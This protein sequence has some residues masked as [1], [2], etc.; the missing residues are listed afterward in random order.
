VG[1]GADHAASHRRAGGADGSR[2]RSGIT[3]GWPR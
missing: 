1:A 3:R 2:P